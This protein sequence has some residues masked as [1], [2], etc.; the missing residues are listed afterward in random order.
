M[1]DEKDIVVEEEV[2][3]DETIVCVQCGQEFVFSAGEKAFFKEKGLQNKPKYCKNCRAAKKNAQRSRE[4][5]E[6][7]PAVCTQC[8]AECM[9][10]FKPNEEKPV[11]CDECFKARR[12]SK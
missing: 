4:P 8:G 9:V 11:Y 3:E 6:M 2:F 1:L 12:E 10:P 7:F 5:R